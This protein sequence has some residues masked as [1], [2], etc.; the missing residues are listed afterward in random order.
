MRF[1]KQLIQRY[2]GIHFSTKLFV[3]FLILCAVPVILIT[4]FFFNYSKK[5]IEES[6][7]H[8]SSLFAAQL[9][10]AISMHLNVIDNTSTELFTDYEI[11]NYLG[12]EDESFPTL[13]AIKQN[14]AVTQ[15]LAHYSTQMPFLQGILILSESGKR[16]TS[17]YVPNSMTE[18]YILEQ[19]WYQEIL[20]AKGRLHLTPSHTITGPSSIPSTVNSFSAGRVL[21]DPEG[22]RAGIILFFLSPYTLVSYDKKLSEISELYKAR[23]ILTTTNN[24]FIFDSQQPDGQADPTAAKSILSDERYLIISDES[25]INGINVIIALSKSV[26]YENIRLYRNLALLAAAVIVIAITISSVVLSIQITKPIKYLVRNMIRVEEGY[27]RPMPE[28]ATSREFH[29]LAN[30]YKEKGKKG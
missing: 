13:N 23:I 26:L 6:S 22:R 27:Y 21:T 2:R 17:G 20:N 19:P 12:Q 8:F 1:F 30:T 3:S 4:L 25:T 11:I 16:Y 28:I 10:H 14:L 24:D 7:T 29:K 5:N 18:P 15:K 9:N